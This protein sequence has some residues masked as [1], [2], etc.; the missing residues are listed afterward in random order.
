MGGV[1]LKGLLAEH[2]PN[3]C[4]YKNDPETD[5]V[6]HASMRESS[7]GAGPRTRTGGQSTEAIV[8]RMPSS[9]PPRD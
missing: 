2:G 8:F 3:C 7:S 5:L 9:K 4:R 6:K 1:L